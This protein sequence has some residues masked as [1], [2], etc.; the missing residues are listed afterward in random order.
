MIYYV[1]GILD[2][3]IAISN[4]VGRLYLA[5]FS[6]VSTI[7]TRSLLPRSFARFFVDSSFDYLFFF[8]TRLLAGRCR[9][10]DHSLSRLLHLTYL[11]G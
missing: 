1:A 6:D 10:H 9:R 7:A 3:S 2:L 5:E 11:T 8:S 4:F